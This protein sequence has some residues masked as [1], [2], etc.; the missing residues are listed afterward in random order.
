[1]N[2]TYFSFTTL[3]TVGYGDL[4]MAESFPQM[5]AVTEAVMG[6]I[7]LVVAVGLLIGNLGRARQVRRASPP[8]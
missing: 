4:T 3:S 8:K 6:Q 2:T 7:Y 5:L 1:M